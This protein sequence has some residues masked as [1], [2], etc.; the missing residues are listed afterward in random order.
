[1]SRRDTF[2]PFEAKGIWCLPGQ[3]LNE[4]VAGI[5]RFNVDGGLTLDLIGTLEAEIQPFSRA[6]EYKVILGYLER[7]SLGSL[8][9]LVD[10][11]QKSYSLSTP[12]FAT[13][14]IRAT[15]AYVG[16]H[17]NTLDSLKFLGAQVH[18]S[19]LLSWCSMRGATTAIDY[20]S[21]SNDRWG[22]TYQ[23]PESRHVAIL[24]ATLSIEYSAVLHQSDSRVSIEENA[25]ITVTCAAEMPADELNSRFVHPLQNLLTFA[26]DRPNSITSYGL[27]QAAKVDVET[28]EHPV[29]YLLYEPV[30]F[31]S[32]PLETIF[33]HDM[34]FSLRDAGSMLD[35]LVARWISLSNELR[36][37][38]EVFFA[39][40]YGSVR[41]VE[42][43]FVAVVEALQLYGDSRLG[44]TAG[45][46][47]K[48]RVVLM[49]KI[50]DLSPD[51]RS[52]VERHLEPYPEE[53]IRETIAALIERMQKP[54]VPIIGR[55]SS[56]FVD[57]VVTAWR[58]VSGRVIP[59][60]ERAGGGARIHWMTERLRFIF[61]SMILSEL[62]FEDDQITQLL[63]RNRSFT[64]VAS[65]TT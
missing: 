20:G 18:I 15:R 4:G 27:V 35:S 42:P 13:Q 53:R 17:F 59:K 32:K 16:E 51:L 37:A 58:Q 11:F 40:V 33:E 28:A 24:G 25:S 39:F 63:L 3:S 65:I 56:A 48:E 41:Y 49:P 61:K 30:Y 22:I 34:L 38:F 52:W 60:G 44:V 5:L 62:G 19:H 1:M 54:L 21:A 64:H 23:R 43:R 31:D 12:G 7:S 57:E 55:D 50:A 2:R 26:T 6:R 46:V 29:V 45:I 10:C 47:A 9:T 36:A 8:I 14:S